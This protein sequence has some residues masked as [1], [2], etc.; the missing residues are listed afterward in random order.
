MVTLYY[1]AGCV[2]ATCNWCKA[3]QFMIALESGLSVRCGCGRPYFRDAQHA[4]RFRLLFNVIPD[5]LAALQSFFDEE[6]V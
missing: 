5:N 1:L 3:S 4:E 2:F 6:P